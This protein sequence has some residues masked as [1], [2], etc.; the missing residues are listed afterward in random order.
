MFLFS[1]PPNKSFLILPWV[2]GKDKYI[3]LRNL[4]TYCS[5][6]LLQLDIYFIMIIPQFFLIC[7][8]FAQ[9]SGDWCIHLKNCLGVV[10]LYTLRRVHTI[11]K[12]LHFW[13]TFL[14]RIR[15]TVLIFKIRKEICNLFVIYLGSLDLAHE[16]LSSSLRAIL[17]NDVASQVNDKYVHPKNLNVVSRLSSVISI[18]WPISNFSFQA[19]KSQPSWNILQCAKHLC[20]PFRI[21]KICPFECLSYI[22]SLKNNCP[23]I[24]I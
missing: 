2:L 16:I 9:L 23:Q 10:I 19:L 1:P 21:G 5:I 12:W 7:L 14:Q 24:R 17:K 13:S 8:E 3:C 6:R 4:S 15:S 18:Q 22:C 20:A 11:L